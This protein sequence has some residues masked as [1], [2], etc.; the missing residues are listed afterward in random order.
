MSCQGS[1]LPAQPSYSALDHGD[2]HPWS[3]SPRRCAPRAYA[4]QVNIQAT[5]HHVHTTVEPR[6]RHTL[7]VT[8]G[9]LPGLLQGAVG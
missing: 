7:D 5:A 8:L 4:L 2:R 3:L 1:G 9:P 6:G